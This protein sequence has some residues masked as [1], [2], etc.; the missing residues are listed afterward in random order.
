MLKKRKAKQVHTSYARIFAFVLA[1]VTAVTSLP[2]DSYAAAKSGVAKGS[3]DARLLDEMTALYEG[4]EAKAKQALDTLYANGLID[5]KGNVDFGETF[6]VE[7]EGNAVQ[8]CSRD[9]LRAL[10]S[11]READA[12]VTVDGVDMTWGKVAQMFTMLDAV[13]LIRECEESDV[14]LTEEHIKALKSLSSQLSTNGL[15][16]TVGEDGVQQLS[17]AELN[18]HAMSATPVRVYFTRSGSS[19]NYTYT[20]NETDTTAAV[21]QKHGLDKTPGAYDVGD[22]ITSAGGK[23]YVDFAVDENSFLYGNASTA[24]IAAGTPTNGTTTYT[25]TLAGALTYDVDFDI[26]ILD[27]SYDSATITAPTAGKTAALKIAAGQTTASFTV[28]DGTSTRRWKGS[29]VYM[30]SVHSD[31]AKIQK[32]G[33]MEQ[34]ANSVSYT[35]SVTDDA[36]NGEASGRTTWWNMSDMP[37]ATGIDLFR[38]GYW[39]Q[40]TG[41]TVYASYSL[42]KLKAIATQLPDLVCLRV[43]L[44]NINNLFGTQPVEAYL[45]QTL[46]QDPSSLTVQIGSPHEFLG[47]GSSVY[48]SQTYGV[49]TKDQILANNYVVVRYQSGINDGEVLFDDEYAGETYFLAAE[50]AID[51]EEMEFDIK[52]PSGVFYPGDKVPITMDTGVAVE[53]LTDGDFVLTVNNEDLNPVETGTA[54]YIGSRLTFLYE[55]KSNDQLTVNVTDL[56][57]NRIGQNAAATRFAGGEFLDYYRYSSASAEKGFYTDTLSA[58]ITNKELVGFDANAIKNT[59]CKLN[60][61]D[62]TLTFLTQDIAPT[63]GTMDS[64]DS[65][66]V[67]RP[68][69]SYR[70]D[71]AIEDEAE[72]YAWLAANAAQDDEGSFYVKS[73]YASNDGGTTRMPV[74]V[75]VDF[76]EFQ[77]INERGETVRSSEKPVGIYVEFTPDVNT[78]GTPQL[79]SVELFMDR[80]IA[81]T[82]DYTLPANA[83]K[84]AAPLMGSDWIFSYVVEPAILLEQGDF[85]IVYDYN[86]AWNSFVPE[87]NP[88]GDYSIPQA[89]DYQINKAEESMTLTYEITGTD[90]YTYAN[91][92]NFTWESSDKTV[93]AVET[94]RVSYMHNEKNI[95]RLLAVVMP[96]GKAGTVTFKLTA[97]NGASDGTGIT[98]TSAE[99]TIV[100]GNEPYISIPSLFKEVETLQNEEAQISFSGNVARNNAKGENDTIDEAKTTEITLSV[101]PCGKN[102][103]A[104]GDSVYEETVNASVAEPVTAMM[105]PENVLDTVSVSGGVSYRAEVSA[106]D[107]ASQTVLSDFALIRVK[108]APIKIELGGV[109]NTYVMDD[110]DFEVSWQMRNVNAISAEKKW[111]YSITKKSNNEVMA[112][113]E[114]TSFNADAMTQTLDLNEALA[115]PDGTL[116]EIYNISVYATN[117][118]EQDGWSADSMLLYVYNAGALD[119][120][121]RESNSA[122]VAADG[123]SVTLDNT[124]YIEGMVTTGPQLTLPDGITLQELSQDVNLSSIVS[125]NYGDYAWGLLNDQ[126]KW[127]V[128]EENTA[129]ASLNYWQGGG[130]SDIEAALM[131][132]FLPTSD[133]MLVA[134]ENGE[135]TVTATHA[136]TGMQ[137]EV[138][139]TAETLKDQLYLFQANPAV[140]TKVMYKNKAGGDVELW[141]DDNGGIAIYEEEGIPGE[142]FF[143]ADV[144]VEDEEEEGV[145]YTDTYMASKDVQELY[146]EEKN[147]ALLQNYPINIVKL[148]KASESVIYLTKPDGTPLANTKVNVRGG[149]YGPDG[150]IANADLQL[151]KGE[152]DTEPYSN[153]LF[154]REFTTSPTGAL[155]VYYDV[156]QFDSGL[157]SAAAAYTYAYELQFKNDEFKPEVFQISQTQAERGSFQ[158]TL[159]AN[160]PGGGRAPFAKNR[161]LSE[162]DNGVMQHEI[163]MTYDITVERIGA[164]TKFDK[165]V[166]DTMTYLWDTGVRR[167]P[168]THQAELLENI[169]SFS[170]KYR[171]FETK[172]ELP[173]QD[174]R[175]IVYPFSS[176]PILS[177]YFT[178]DVDSYGGVKHGE[179]DYSWDGAWIEGEEERAVEIDFRIEGVQKEIW[180]CAYEVVNT[181]GKEEAVES[182]EMSDEATESVTEQLDFDINKILGDL[183]PGGDILA[184]GLTFFSGLA[185]G[186]DYTIGLTVVPTADPTIYNIVLSVGEHEPEEGDVSMDYADSLDTEALQDAFGSMDDDDDDEEDGD[187]DVEFSFSGTLICRATYDLN[188]SEWDIRM[189]GGEVGGKVGVSKD[190]T[191]NF[192]VLCVPVTISISA[193]ASVG[194]KFGAKTQ[195]VNGR[196]EASTLTSI[197]IGAGIEAFVGVGF[198]YSIIALKIGIFGKV[199]FE[200]TQ[201]IMVKEGSGGLD[202]AQGQNLNIEGEV[203]IK[204]VAKLLMLKYEK[205]F[206]SVS[207]GWEKSWNDYDQITSYWEGQT[208]NGRSYAAT[209][210]ADGQTLFQLESVGVEDRD[211]L[212]KYSRVWV[213]NA[214]TR[215]AG[216]EGWFKD[217]M[218]NAYPYADPIFSDDGEILV[219]LSDEDSSDVEE[220]VACWAKWNGSGYTRMGPIAR[221]DDDTKKT[222]GYGDSSLSLSGRDGHYV[223]GWVQQA[224]SLELT[225]ADLGA[226][227]TVPGEGGTVQEVSNEAVANSIQATEIMT[228]V[229]DAQS[230]TWTAKRM[231]ENSTPDLAPVLTSDGSGGAMLFWRS[232]NASSSENPL[233]FDVEDKIFGIRYVDGAWRD[234]EPMIIYSGSNGPVKG[235]GGAL[236]DNGAAVA[237]YTV[238]TGEAE[239]STDFETFY[240]YIG[241]DGEIETVRVTQNATMDENIQVAYVKNEDEAGAEYGMFLLGWYTDD[242]EGSSDIQMLAV[243][244]DGSLDMTFPENISSIGNIK[245]TNT[246]RFAPSKEGTLSGLAIAWVE[247]VAMEKDGAEVDVSTLQAVKL[248]QYNGVYRVTGGQKMAEAGV[249][250]TI[251][252]F[253]VFTDGDTVHAVANTTDYSAGN[254]TLEGVIDLAELVTQAIG[255]ESE[256]EAKGFASVDA[257]NEA[258]Q[259]E[260]SRLVEEYDGEELEIVSPDGEAKLVNAS[261][262]FTNGIEILDTHYD[263]ESVFVGA[264]VPVT[265]SVGNAGVTPI[266]KLTVLNGEAVLTE[267]DMAEAPLL[268][269]ETTTV[270]AVYGLDEKIA[271]IDFKVKADLL[272]EESSVEAEGILILNRPDIGIGSMDLVSEADGIREIN[273]KL[274]NKGEIPLKGNNKTIEVQYFLD[275]G[276]TIP[277]TDANGKVKTVIRPEDAD[278]ME[279]IDSGA[280]I[281][282]LHVDVAAALQT[283]YRGEQTEI[284]ESGVTVYAKAAV[285][286]EYETEKQA[287]VKEDFKANN[288]KNVTF[289]S[290]TAKTGGEELSFEHIAIE[291]DD[292]NN[293]LTVAM[294]VSNNMMAPKE[295][296]NLMVELLDKDGNVLASQQTFDPEKTLAENT[297]ALGTEEA[298][299]QELTFDRTKIKDA[300]K[301]VD[302]NCYVCSTEAEVTFDLAGKATGVEPQQ[303]TLGNMVTIPASNPAS[304]DYQFE[305]WYTDDSYRQEFDFAN[306]KITKDTT[307]YAKWKSYAPEIS[308]HPKSF[309]AEYNGKDR[310]LAVTADCVSGDMTYQWYKNGTAITDATD[311][312][313]QVREVADSGTYYCEVTADVDNTPFRVFTDAAEVEITKRE[314]TVTSDSESK[315]FDGTALTKDSYTITEG[316]LGYGDKLEVK[317]EASVTERGEVPNT[318]KSAVLKRGEDDVTD[319]YELTTLN[320]TL[321]ITKTEAEEYAPLLTAQPA[322]VDGFYDAKTKTLAVTA[323]CDYAMTYQWYKNGSA[324]TGAVNRTLDVK[325][326]SDSGTYYCK[327]SADIKG[328]TAVVNSAS[329]SVSI[330][331][332]PIRI[333]ANSVSKVHDGRELKAA[334]YQYSGTLLDGQKL[335]VTISGSITKPGSKTNKINAVTIK[336]GSKD[337]SQN[338]AIET[339]N[340][341]LKVTKGSNYYVTYNKNTK[342]AVTG[343]KLDINRYQY[344]KKA[345][346]SSAPSGSNQ[347][348]TGWNTKADGSG[349]AYKAGAKMTVTT[350]VTLYAQWQKTYTDKAKLTY[351]VN[352]KQKTVTVTGTTK[353]KAATIKIPGTIKYK[354][355]TYKVTRIGKRAFQGMSKLKKVTL[356]K[357]ITLIGEKAFYNCKKLKSVTIGKKVEL[358]G[359]NVF[360]G[361]KTTLTITVK[362]NKIKNPERFKIKGKKVTIKVPAV[363]L[364]R[365]QKA[366]KGTGIKIKK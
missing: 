198:D 348:F 86:G 213:A 148:N 122:A 45:A 91:A 48:F 256:W 72:L 244:D 119:V 19:G 295:V 40:I 196:E 107:E 323:D 13:E 353:K 189:T 26:K 88:A 157:V 180:P 338:Y 331:K 237:A 335:S 357:E 230:D 185:T 161:V 344:N 139:G 51:V 296:G 43:P 240:S 281:T 102:G 60:T 121:V 285:Y 224:E 309:Q 87:D 321:R 210:F 253:D 133:F 226:D 206:G 71:V 275:S 239:D 82:I 70:L 264:Q 1:I 223:A 90:E 204:F 347:F 160:K 49:V 135:F 358:L 350:N 52:V 343:M 7:E 16:F 330:K 342:S 197:T 175:I 290:L 249:G 361:G 34:A 176:F 312:T 236:S 67:K 79:A 25:L 302:V 12:K 32:D 18:P 62:K 235:I 294:N 56:K 317:T 307:I 6:S 314:L 24:T 276:H 318:I 315:R 225:D 44:A 205:T 320:G 125:I 114:F 356:G 216:D 150:Y 231:T 126:I 136:N 333:E 104:T 269:G 41:G 155:T 202:F 273:V 29:Q 301:V 151:V 252:Y 238:K 152:V 14:P 292:E 78:S 346:V 163:D 326:V 129:G 2:L 241:T 81:S 53:G 291:K 109:P 303:V 69:G 5:E 9:E 359:K 108:S 169:P 282:R 182:V 138:T 279:L 229:L 113:E 313:Y 193:E 39:D 116:K 300:D 363:A 105:I 55:V 106:L 66:F 111:R 322:D 166:L 173:G 178:M 170:A 123:D 305:G 143:R 242:G 89:F 128:Q 208:T 35:C 145:T 120:I 311:S 365:Y 20:V 257:Y 147:V 209:T 340:G 345:K 84:K 201:K 4:D 93:A 327:I 310:T 38:Y 268:P 57:G 298:K 270:T 54:G 284:P 187:S 8:T 92:A 42:D 306:T 339:V 263:T 96:T 171:D 349:K 288:E 188:S 280:Y 95:Q 297:I 184:K 97:T 181:L 341:K 164:S 186:G 17:L 59:D 278:A 319:N 149:V 328:E 222:Y 10:S 329:A 3:Y 233:D 144:E 177:N 131:P 154:D 299:A 98:L 214:S 247:K 218:T 366:V 64:I 73:M 212:N 336:D 33:D 271:D 207:F 63:D 75:N 31:F 100:E 68:D 245:P 110:E 140:K 195:V 308:K 304:S 259:A 77:Y 316:S 332:V 211:Y 220:T 37:T 334:G 194:A 324:I 158:I 141:T 228:A 190:Y 156:D 118:E 153:G 112:E 283:L 36:T 337:V 76:E 354:G 293:T 254:Y 243:K 74:Y 217:L 23:Y 266:G 265:F 61:P 130:Y 248:Y 183:V 103:E 127:K 83:D 46:H 146:T 227:G 262:T 191:Q 101:F 15:S 28:N 192:T 260:Y 199:G 200:L 360:A 251:D 352:S 179:Y 267:E 50:T 215:A 364:K 250:G 325:E 165:V 132:S 85:E 137:S 142:V 115:L 261:Y 246:F 255:K 203:G 272:D 362:G 134:T 65:S 234:E 94:K 287:A 351:L 117:D 289:K 167:N 11:K 99:L 274:L 172:Q 162:Y 58:K 258:W 277:L 27:G 47:Y 174:E 232:A 355:I 22:Y 159:L 80:D 221:K 21:V 286:D 30:V 168:T 124:D 219:Y